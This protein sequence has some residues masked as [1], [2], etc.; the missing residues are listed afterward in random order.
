M[1]HTTLW[2]VVHRIE[3]G[4][5][6][7]L[8]ILFLAAITLVGTS[9]SPAAGHHDPDLSRSAPPSGWTG[10]NLTAPLAHDGDDATYSTY[11][12]ANCAGGACRMGV[13]W[14]DT[15]NDGVDFTVRSFRARWGIEAPFTTRFSDARWLECDG[16]QVWRDDEDIP[17]PSILR[18]TGRIDFSEAV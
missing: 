4:T 2:G 16:V 15:N 8:C 1:L 12:P 10:P 13:S 18:D 5:S 3:P 9:V 11:G 7:S 6:R 17:Y 14:S